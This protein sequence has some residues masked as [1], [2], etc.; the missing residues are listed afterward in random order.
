MHPNFVH[1][2]LEIEALYSFINEDR[3][4]FWY[5]DRR[6]RIL[7]FEIKLKSRKKEKYFRKKI[8][9]VT[10]YDLLKREKRIYNKKQFKLGAFFD[11]Y[12]RYGHLFASKNH[13]V[14]YMHRRVATGREDIVKKAQS[15]IE[16]HPECMV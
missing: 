5:V 1:G 9:F 13:A 15:Y 7:Q 4:T 8:L 3:K 11:Q 2:S 6:A 12:L 16:L 14:K 10:A